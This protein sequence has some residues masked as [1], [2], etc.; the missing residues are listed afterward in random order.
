MG[1]SHSLFVIFFYI[2]AVCLSE[3]YSSQPLSDKQQIKLFEINNEG[4]IKV[5]IESIEKIRQIESPI[6]VVSSLGLARSGKTTLVNLISGKLQSFEGKD[7]K[8]SD[9]VKWV[10]NNVDGSIFSNYTKNIDYIL[11]DTESLVIGRGINSSIKLA[12]LTLILSDYVLVNSINEMDILLI[13]FT[14][15]LIS[16][17]V[18]FS[19]L[20]LRKLNELSVPNKKSLKKN[21]IFLVENLH[22]TSISWILHRNINSDEEQEPEKFSRN[23]KDWLK[24]KLEKYIWPETSQ[25]KMCKNLDSFIERFN[26]YRIPYFGTEKKYNGYRY[27]SI[28]RGQYHDQDQDHEFGKGSGRS[29]FL[30]IFKPGSGEERRLTGAEFADL[31]ELFSEHSYIFNSFKPLNFGI[32]KGDLKTSNL[33]ENTLLIFG[34]RLENQLLNENMYPLLE[35]EADAIYNK[36]LK[37]IESYWSSIS[38]FD[39][40]DFSSLL[41]S[42]QPHFEKQYKSI[43]SKNCERIRSHCSDVIDIHISHAI[44][45]IEQFYEKIPIPQSMLIEFTKNLEAGILNDIEM[46]LNKSFGSFE[47][48]ISSYRNSPCCNIDGSL[49]QEKIESALSKLRKRNQEEI[50]KILLNDFE[51]ALSMIRSLEEVDDSYYKVSKEDFEKKL[52]K[53]KNSS[54]LVFNAHTTIIN[55][56][57]LHSRYWNRL[58][59]ELDEFIERKMLTWKKVCRK[60]SYNFAKSIA[61][62]QNISIR[63]KLTLPIADSVILESFKNLKDNVNKEMNGIYCS[64]EESW[65]DALMELMSVIEDD[66]EQ[67]MKENL[68]ALKN[69]LHRPLRYALI[70]AM[71]IAR[72][73]YSWM[74]FVREATILAQNSLEDSDS[75]GS[76][77]ID[78][79]TKDRV[80]ELWIEMDLSGIRKGFVRNQIFMIVRYLLYSLIFTIITFIT[81]FKNNSKLILGVVFLS[82]IASV[83]LFSSIELGVA[84]E[85]ITHN[86]TDLFVYFGIS[87]FTLHYIRQNIILIFAVLVGIICAAVYVSLS[88]KDGN[89]C[90]NSNPKPNSFQ[91]KRGPKFSPRQ[92][93]T[94]SNSPAASPSLGEK[95]KHQNKSSNAVKTFI[96]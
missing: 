84:G 24:S 45:Q 55:E 44:H 73:H 39:Y 33:V 22:K 35:I 60:Y 10:Q 21:L 3:V 20:F 28:I 65:K 27:H 11:L 47:S 62:R 59:S 71:E 94:N 89:S 63:N 68:I 87:R 14:R 91:E 12:I 56:T 72:Q 54:R 19:S 6:S 57:D 76:I 78:S 74:N 88:L 42:V 15:L 80:I 79:K 61:I 36:T 66:K 58:N 70:N 34:T 92:K 26:F 8:E 53:M 25:S 17:A 50:E 85:T 64:N 46:A 7:E 86:L 83:L 16:K 38:E 31:L 43:L 93:L 90:S 95:L 29:M 4:D 2:A 77:N 82:F 13:D 49:T 67:L 18:M 9:G 51:Q 96:F 5:P 1:R 69:L 41:K 30:D 75:W 81:L 32:T 48:D 52:E 40:F 37:D 23:Y